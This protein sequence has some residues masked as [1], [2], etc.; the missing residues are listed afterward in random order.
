MRKKKDK[1][2][3]ITASVVTFLCIVFVV[4]FTVGLNSVLAMEGAYPPVVNAES[5]SPV[6]ETKEDLI[7]YLNLVTE[8]MLKDK[9]A[10]EN[11]D[12]F[13]IEEKTVETDGSEALKTTLLYC[14]DGSSF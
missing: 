5:L 6:P 11:G 10:V 9:P 4:G 7:A 2:K 3:I 12:A 8:K 13:L 1:S 14:R